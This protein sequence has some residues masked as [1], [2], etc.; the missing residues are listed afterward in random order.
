MKKALQLVITLAVVCWTASAGAHSMWLNMD[1]HLFTKGQTVTVDIGWGHKFPKDGELKA[2]MLKEIVA[3]APDGKRI[4]LNKTSESRFAFVP[5]ETGAYVIY[6]NIHP[7]FVSRTTQGYKMVPKTGLDKVIACF[8]YDIR[9]RT[10]IR[11]GDP[12]NI[13]VPGTGGPLEILSLENTFTLTTGADLPVKVLF[14]GKPI[15]G[16]R[17]CATY[18]GFSD[19]PNDFAQTVET[20]EDGIAVIKI[21]HKGD[22]MISVTHEIPYSNPKEC[23]TNKYNAT[24]TF[25]VP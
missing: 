13:A 24:M 2:G 6:A 12:A 21:A 9:T 1:G 5:E 17:V 19:K 4:P 7:G 16:A 11:V 14:N 3:I 15:S 10:S 22:W 25:D 20:A 18:A 8:H 23:D